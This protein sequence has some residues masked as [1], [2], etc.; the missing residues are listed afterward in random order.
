MLIDD[1]E[2]DILTINA[3]AENGFEVSIDDFG[4]GYS[5][6]SY[7]RKFKI[8]KIKIDRSFILDIDTVAGAHIVQGIIALAH[9]IGMEVVAE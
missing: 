8:G 7:L 5:S 1:A 6:L 3:F 4:T 2:S 9:S